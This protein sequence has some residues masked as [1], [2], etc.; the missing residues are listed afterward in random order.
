MSV[1]LPAY[2]TL[3]VDVSRK[4]F[5]DITMCYLPLIRYNLQTS[6]C[7]EDKHMENFTENMTREISAITESISGPDEEKKFIA[8][9]RFC[10]DR[11]G[12]DEPVQ[13]IW[14]GWQELNA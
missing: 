14:R 8:F 11:L 2:H 10:L 1:F 13:D 6:Y 3:W 9:L 5:C 12:K 7:K 4:I